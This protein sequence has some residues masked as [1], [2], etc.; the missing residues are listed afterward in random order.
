MFRLFLNKC[1]AYFD[2][3]SALDKKQSWTETTRIEAKRKRLFYDTFSISIEMLLA[4]V[5]VLESK[6]ETNISLT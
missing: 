3:N 4:A 6:A 1:C 5:Y 2:H